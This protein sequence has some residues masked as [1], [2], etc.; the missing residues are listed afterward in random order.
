MKKIIIYEYDLNNRPEFLTIVEGMS[1][2]FL[3]LFSCSDKDKLA[4]VLSNKN[5][6]GFVFDLTPLVRDED[7][8]SK[9]AITIEI[10][11]NNITDID[12]FFL[13]VD[14]RYTYNILDLLFYKIED[15]RSFESLLDMH[16]PL[17][18]NI[19]TMVEDDFISL[20][21]AIRKN[22]IGNEQ[23]KIRLEH[24]LRKYRVFNRVGYQPIFSVLICGKSG[25]GKTELARI[26]HRELSPNEPFIKIN[27]GNYSDQ[28]ALSSL[29]GS[30]RGYIGSSK[31]ELSIKLNNS[32]SNIILIDEFEKCNKQVQNFFLQLLEDGFFTDS[33]GRDYNLNKYVIVFTANLDKDK[34]N[35]VIAPELLSRINLRY[36]FSMLNDIEKKEYVHHK[37]K[38]ILKDLHEYDINRNDEIFNSMNDIDVTRYTNMRDINN[39]IM[40]RIS[41]IIY[42]DVCTS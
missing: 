19:A 29:I 11:I 3:T 23:F 18:K 17:N 2:E 40:N 26:I 9:W 22:L 15:I 14:K 32:K 24:E 4:E 20:L 39:E 6:S 10:I 35:Q 33:L 42:N 31:G 36:A 28:N 16:I 34:V 30:P 25:I 41:D 12:N 38:Q 37:T 21:A 13:I 5:I 7:S 8:A 27:F 1:F